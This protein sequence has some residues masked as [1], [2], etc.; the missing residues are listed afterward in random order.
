MTF[1]QAWCGATVYSY[2]TVQEKE[3]VKRWMGATWEIVNI[4]GDWEERARERER[5]RERGNYLKK[6]LM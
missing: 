2:F 6:K 1:I 3:I 5:D 4:D